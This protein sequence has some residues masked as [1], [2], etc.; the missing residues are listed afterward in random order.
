MPLFGRK[1]RRYRI[2]FDVHTWVG[3]ATGL[4]LFVMFFTGVVA[5][6]H[7]PI[8]AWEEP[9]HHHEAAG[10]L[11]IWM[12]ELVALAPDD[13]KRVAVGMPQ[14]AEGMR[15]PVGF[16]ESAPGVFE[17]YVR[18]DGAWRPVRTGA[19]EFLYHL[20]FLYHASAPWLMNLAG[21]VS[22][23][24]LLAVFTGLVIHLR[25][26]VPQLRRFRPRMPRQVMWSDLHK[27]TAVIGIPFQVVMTYTGAIIV[28]GTFIIGA[29]GVSLYRGDVQALRE[30]GYG[31]PLPPPPEVPVE[32][33]SPPPSQ[34]VRAAERALPELEPHYVDVTAYGTSAA[35]V[36]IG[37]SVP[38][39]PGFFYVWLDGAETQVLQV[40]RPGALPPTETA[41]RWLFALHFSQIGGLG[42]Q[43]VYAILGLFG[44]AALLSGN[45]L[46]IERK[47]KAGM[48]RGVRWLSRLTTGIGVGTPVAAGAIL[49]SS[50]WLP[51]FDARIA[52]EELIF[53]VA[54]LASCG[55]SFR[56]EDAGEVWWRGLTLAA[57]LFAL[58][59]V[60]Q[61]TAG[62]VGLLSSSPQRIP[63]LV[64][65]GFLL[66]AASLQVA[67]H[68]LRRAARS[69]TAG[70]IRA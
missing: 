62:G 14:P 60:A 24:L 11:D 58:L 2:A 20:H 38:R 10:S 54:L 47:R 6:F 31:E 32:V 7:E 55:W 67:S 66:A 46:W 18:T 12:Q 51:S 25:D 43:L 41:T 39:E 53:F 29:V 69:T 30:A 59:P 49:L 3:I 42:M 5:L 22:I 50:Q 19:G 26:L 68:W 4:V 70:A 56:A 17:E 28:L 8:A 16:V 15:S 63:M 40:R 23:A 21:I 36:R 64:D 57:L 13:A 61:A 37:G 9:A 48:G 45:A 35:R 44:C 52:V 65:V 34:W 1:D 33:A 27:V